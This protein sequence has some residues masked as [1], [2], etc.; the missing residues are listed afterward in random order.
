MA[1]KAHNGAVE[2]I[3][4][5]TYVSDM[6]ENIDI[7]PLQLLLMMQAASAEKSQRFDKGRRD[8]RLNSRGRKTFGCSIHLV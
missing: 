5:E 4:P 2:M 3:R 1:R 8:A 7:S 6:E